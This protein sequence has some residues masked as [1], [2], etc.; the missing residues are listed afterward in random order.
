MLETALDLCALR[1]LIAET[2][3]EG[4][5]VLDLLLLILVSSL[6][7][8]Q[9]LLTQGDVVTV[10]SLVV[11]DASQLNLNGAVGHVVEEGTVV[12]DEQERDS[13]GDEE[14]LEPV[15]RLDV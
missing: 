2:L 14:V 4:L 10:G 15:D 5:D 6:L 11:V 3:D 8:L 1:R 9:T 12:R 7:L 13:T